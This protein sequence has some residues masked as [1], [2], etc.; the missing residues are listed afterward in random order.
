MRDGFTRRVQRKAVGTGGF[1]VSHR[2]SIVTLSGATSGNEY[3]LENE[4]TSIG[5]GPG[6]DIAFDDQ[7]MSREHAAFEVMDGAMWLRDL[8]STNHVL[9]N[10]GQTR[11]AQLEN[12]DKIDL[13]EHRFQ[14]VLEKRKRV[15]K[16]YRIEQG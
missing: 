14:F 1:L 13:G 7:T 10:G 9:V 4:R 16:S 8:G 5:R 12:G 15:P 3:E 6:V 2:A 11:S